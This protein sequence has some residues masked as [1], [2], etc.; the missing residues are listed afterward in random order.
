LVWTVRTIVIKTLQNGGASCVV[1]R[2]NTQVVDAGHQKA[3]GE[4]TLWPQ[5]LQVAA[6]RWS[7]LLCRWCTAVV[8]WAHSF[9]NLSLSPLYSVRCL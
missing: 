1:R 9:S 4:E 2:E 3:P 7:S 5:A 8:L 6:L